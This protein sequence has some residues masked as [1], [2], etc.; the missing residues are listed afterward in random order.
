MYA[1]FL[2]CS[3]HCCFVKMMLVLIFGIALV[4]GIKNSTASMTHNKNIGLRIA[5]AIVLVVFGK[6]IMLDYP[7]VHTPIYEFLNQKEL[8]LFGPWTQTDIVL[9]LLVFCC[10]GY[11]LVRQSSSVLI[12]L[13]SLVSIFISFHYSQ[14]VFR[15]IPISAVIVMVFLEFT[16]VLNHNQSPKTYSENT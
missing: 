9:L 13:L 1:I 16:R 11:F 12:A 15:V 5:G 8:I 3:R 7:A 14:V 10:F 6:S 2:E 4:C